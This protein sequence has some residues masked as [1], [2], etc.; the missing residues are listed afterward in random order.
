LLEGEEEGCAETLCGTELADGVLEGLV[1]VT[2][3]VLEEGSL[4]ELGLLEGDEDGCAK[5]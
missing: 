1:D 3:E 4:L 5:T 2:F